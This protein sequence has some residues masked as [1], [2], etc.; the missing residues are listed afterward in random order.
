MMQASLQKLAD[1][2]VETAVYCAHEYTLSNLRFA[3]AV[4]PDNQALQQR[5]K[6]D[7][8]TR[9][10]ER[11]TVPSTIGTELQTN[12]FLRCDQPEVIAMA[13]EHESGTPADPAT[14][15]GVLRRW[16]DNF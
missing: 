16:K 3:S 13:S 14:V 5:I 6:H 11:P 10:A 12:P 1:L 8:A 4:M 15:F 7:T 9:Q 2:P